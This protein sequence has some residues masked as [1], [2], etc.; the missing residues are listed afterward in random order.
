MIRMACPGCNAKLKADDSSEGKMGACPRCGTKLTAG[1]QSPVPTPSA[2]A[3]ASA[4]VV[5]ETPG[6]VTIDGKQYTLQGDS[7][8]SIRESIANGTWSGYRKVEVGDDVRAKFERF[9]G[10]SSASGRGAGKESK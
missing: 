5:T 10:P 9:Y 8:A 4:P 1:L 3:P 6:G 2:P 7:A